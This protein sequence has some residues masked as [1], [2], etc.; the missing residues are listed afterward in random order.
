MQQAM[1]QIGKDIAMAFHK[2][3]MDFSKADAVAFFG[4]AIAGMQT[5]G[6]SGTNLNQAIA[7]LA[8]GVKDMAQ[9]LG[10]TTLP[11]SLA[12]GVA[13]GVSQGGINLDAATWDDLSG[14][15][16]QLTQLETNLR[17]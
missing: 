13:I 9:Q 12:Q 1:Q 4:S 17:T 7:M 6:M 5:G 3:P 10:D 2:Y 14:S 15:L 11:M 8:S 16:S